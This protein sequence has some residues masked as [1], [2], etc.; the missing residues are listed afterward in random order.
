MFNFTADVSNSGAN[1]I[2]ECYSTVYSLVKY[3]E[4]RFTQFDGLTPLMAGFVQN[5]VGNVLNFNSI[6]QNIIN[7]SKSGRT[8]DVYFYFGRLVYLLMEF[9]PVQVISQN[10]Q[11]TPSSPPVAPAP[12]P[13]P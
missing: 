10:T 6:Y 9:Q 7:A 4:T 1:A 11:S 12:A 8:T 2:G 13:T 3:G 5:I